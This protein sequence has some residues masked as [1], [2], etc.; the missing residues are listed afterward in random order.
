MKVTTAV[1]QHGRP[2]KGF[3]E[4]PVTIR[5]TYKK[6]PIYFGFDL[7]LLPE[8]FRK[9]SSSKL[10]ERMTEIVAKI[11][12]RHE[13]VKEIIKRLNPFNFEDFRREYYAVSPSFLA[14][15][16]QNLSI[17]SVKIA[18]MIRE[19]PEPEG[20][21]FS[22]HT[23]RYGKRKFNRVRSLVNYQVLGPLAEVF[24]DYI[25]ELEAEDKIGTCE[26]YFSSLTSLLAYKPTMRME[27]VTK[28]FL[29]AYQ[30]WMT[31]KGNSLTTVG[32]YLR[33]L[34][35]LYNL[36]IEDG[37]I[38]RDLYPFGKGR[39]QYQIPTGRN[40]KKFLELA[41]IKLLYDYQPKTTDPNELLG[42]DMWFFLFYGNGMNPK[43]LAMLKYRDIDGD[44]IRFLREKTKNTTVSNPQLISIPM[45]DDLRTYIDRWGNQDKRPDNFVFPILKQGLSAH[46]QKELVQLFVKIINNTIGFIAKESGI[47]KPVRCMWARHS[48]ATI[49]L[50]A[51]ASL[52]YIRQALGHMSSKTTQ[53]YVGSFED[54]A[55]KELSGQLVAFKSL[56][57]AKA[58]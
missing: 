54:A 46:R 47:T 11:E 58:V 21:T 1:R 30:K 12:E 50:R 7:S 57:T 22:G 32:M 42:R 49:M 53:A 26:S 33:N 9:I 13:Q 41:E 43:D 4:I 20:F 15:Q 48:Y 19:A 23:R 6:V 55:K 16:D 37:M 17:E 10:G 38:G 2:R 45:N 24:G 31:D 27:D 40:F 36:Q 44:Y 28:P 8:D 14:E 29:L 56:P 39:R 34:R 3:K 35:A 52:E 18:Q 5:V 25:K 51:G